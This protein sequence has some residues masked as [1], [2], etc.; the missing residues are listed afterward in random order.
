[1]NENIQGYID[2]LKFSLDEEAHIPSCIKDMDW[3]GL[4]EFGNKQA[5]NGILYHGLLKLKDSKYRPNKMIIFRWYSCYQKIKED[6]QRVYKDAA[7]LTYQLLMD[8]YKGC[9]LK[10][11]GN[12]MMYPDPYMRTSGD[13][14]M[15]TMPTR[16]RI[17]KYGP[18]KNENVDIIKYILKQ[19]SSAEICYHHIDYN[20]FD[21]TPVEIHYF[22]SFMGNIFHE[23]RLRRWFSTNKKEQFAKL[24]DI[25]DG[26]GGKICVPTDSFNCIF[27]M[28]HIMHHFFFEGIG[29]RQMI[30]Y[31]YLLKRG[32]TEDEK[33]KLNNTMKSLHMLKF[34]GGIMWI[35]KEILGINENYLYVKPNE[36]I[37]KLF[38]SEI[39]Q[40]GNFGYYDDRYD[41]SGM[42]SYVQYFLETYRNLH[43]AIYFPSETIWGRPLSRW[44]HMIYKMWLT[45]KA[46][47]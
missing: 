36:K 2:F 14:D 22:P 40:S 16:Q 39:I 47:K 1:M 19:D 6:N 26:K 8:G 12:A 42:S 30:D 5:I 20:V 27:Q 11:Q 34:A 46:T 41:F 44:W 4:Y 25:P 13:I 29:L 9:V 32:M 38:Y 28:S 33:R 24:I 18:I 23:V 10:G 15:W 31:Y 21:K 35:L 7:K 37:G 43:Y 3:D 45:K 17:E